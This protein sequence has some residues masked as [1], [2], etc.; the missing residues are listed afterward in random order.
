[1]SFTKIIA[2]IL[3]DA[4]GQER[5]QFLAPWLKNVDQKVLGI[6][7]VHARFLMN[8]FI[9]KRF[10]DDSNGFSPETYV[11]NRIRDVKESIE[12]NNISK[13]E[14]NARIAKVRFLEQLL[15]LLEDLSNII[16]GVV[17]EGEIT[18]VVQG[19]DEIIDTLGTIL[20]SMPRTSDGMIDRDS[21]LVS[22][23]RNNPFRSNLII[24]INKLKDQLK[25]DFE[26]TS[27]PYTPR[28][29][30]ELE[31]MFTELDMFIFKHFSIADASTSS[32]E[33]IRNSILDDL[34]LVDT[35]IEDVSGTFKERL[36]ETI[37]HMQIFIDIAD[38]ILRRY[39]H[40]V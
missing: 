26:R 20:A 34:T 36:K 38:K 28:T 37:G 12:R 25:D 14:K 18:A 22:N 9:E 11:L 27:D 17:I 35:G 21:N 19:S 1:M 29:P 39:L 13:P 33:K 6:H 8:A 24:E 7:R 30:D 10:L 3:I 5:A 32:L 16:A 23:L 4:V 40:S 15:N 31:K 2:G